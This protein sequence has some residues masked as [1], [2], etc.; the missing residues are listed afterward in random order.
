MSSRHDGIQREGTE[1]MSETHIHACYDCQKV[2]R[3]IHG[4]HTSRPCPNCG[5]TAT[6]LCPESQW[7]ELDTDA[8]AALYN[9][10]APT[11][12]ARLT[13]DEQREA[14][15]TPSTQGGDASGAAPSTQGNG[16][17][18]ANLIPLILG[19]VAAALFAH[20]GWKMLDITSVGTS[21]YDTTS[22]GEVFYHTMGWFSFGMALL[23][24]NLGY[25]GWKR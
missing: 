12:D 11:E 10:H 14:L 24:A 18:G 1:P 3:S 21:R 8:K 7:Q 9:D 6:Y 13:T 2:F 23:S 17:S 20:A 19:L 5:H 16:A 4:Q 15:A 25:M 22:I